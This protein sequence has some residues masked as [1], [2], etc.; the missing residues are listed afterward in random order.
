MLVSRLCESLSKPDEQG[1]QHAR[2][3]GLDRIVLCDSCLIM[4]S[5]C[6]RV[7]RRAGI[8]VRTWSVLSPERIS[9]FGSSRIHWSDAA[10]GREEREVPDGDHFRRLA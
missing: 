5:L 1:G 8:L 6:W 2:L 10:I 9:N 7:N 3:F 4:E